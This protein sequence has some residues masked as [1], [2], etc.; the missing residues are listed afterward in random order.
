MYTTTNKLQFDELCLEPI[1]EQLSTT[2]RIIFTLCA[3][4]RTEQNWLY[5]QQVTLLLVFSLHFSSFF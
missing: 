5:D 2:K 3:S 4:N 1:D